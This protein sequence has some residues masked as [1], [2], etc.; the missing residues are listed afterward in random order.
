MLPGFYTN[1]KCTLTQIYAQQIELPII[2]F[3]SFENVRKDSLDL[4]NQI[5]TK[6]KTTH[7]TTENDSP[8]TIKELE[9]LH[10]LPD[11]KFDRTMMCAFFYISAHMFLFHKTLD[12]YTVLPMVQLHVL[13][14]GNFPQHLC[15]KNNTL[16]GH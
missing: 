8:I 5:N 13:S 15:Y 4:L 2:L 12:S 16:Q 9:Y 1:Q 6:A 7:G 11:G 14:V 3:A 10:T